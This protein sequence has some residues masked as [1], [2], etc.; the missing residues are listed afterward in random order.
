MEIISDPDDC[1]LAPPAEWSEWSVCLRDGVTCGFRWGKRTRTRGGSRTS[2]EKAALL[3]PSHSE[4]E[5][6][7][8]RK[9]CPTDDEEGPGAV[10][11][12]RGGVKPASNTKETRSPT[13]SE[14]TD[15]DNDDQEAADEAVS[16]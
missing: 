14:D 15:L 6:C 8:M 11:G 7:K 9:K 2:E 4:T 16:T 13:Q 12:G 3:C 1:L 5:R 10:G